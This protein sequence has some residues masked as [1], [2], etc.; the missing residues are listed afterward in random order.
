M[1]RTLGDIK[2]H[3]YDPNQ[4]ITT[5]RRSTI[6]QAKKGDISGS[7]QWSHKDIESSKRS[8]FVRSHTSFAKMVFFISLG[9]FLISVTYAGLTFYHRTN[10]VSSDKILLSLDLPPFIDSGDSVD[11]ALNIKN[12]NAVAL[13]SVVLFAEIKSPIGFGSTKKHTIKIGSMLPGESVNQ[14][15]PVTILGEQGSQRKINLLM[16]YRVAGSTSFFEKSFEESITL[17][18][19]PIEIA[20]KS[21]E[22]AVSGQIHDIDVSVRSLSKE[23]MSN[24]SLYAEY[25]PGFQF[26]GSATDSTNGNLW[27]LGD[28]EP[29]GEKLI[30]LSGIFNGQEGEAKTIRFFITAGDE[31]TNPSEDA[32]SSYIGRFLLVEPSIVTEIHLGGSTN[33]TI[34]V[35]DDATLSGELRWGNLSGQKMK[36]VKILLS[37]TGDT[38]VSESVISEGTYILKDRTII[39]NSENTPKL[40]IVDPGS[41]GSLKFSFGFKYQ[42]NQSFKGDPEI[43][44]AVRVQAIDPSGNLRQLENSDSMVVK[45]STSVRT[46]AT[47]LH[48]TGPF[49]NFGPIPPRVDEATSYT[50]GWRLVNT[51]S[52]VSDTK[53]TTTLPFQVEWLSAQNVSIG[54]IS[55]NP[56][57]RQIIWD[58]GR[59]D[60]G[61]S[62]SAQSP[63]AYFQ[64]AVTPT[65]GQLGKVVNLTG[66]V[67]LS[68]KDNFTDSMVKSSRGPSST[69][70]SNESGPGSDGRVVR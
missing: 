19:S 24:V 20:I 42:N 6:H 12:G 46:I 29:S 41:Q 18:S 9:F 70:L 36:N 13:D 39:W 63:E 35:S 23:V 30:S 22:E 26:V 27:S 55:Y 45:G 15:V 10:V 69:A 3:L 34:V 48:K 57:T 21:R 4:K 44:L 65:L 59:V 67:E 7:K 49:L 32:L 50:V 40:A 58:V 33:E 17:R 62:L 51:V 56:V 5:R 64:V 52:D 43:R 14:V 53:V 31:V 8:S 25:P 11:L 47:S 61:A 68:A 2:K 16:Q 37:M 54:K 28:I 38:L 60:K 1:R 66:P